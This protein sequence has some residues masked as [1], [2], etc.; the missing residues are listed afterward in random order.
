MRTA[1]TRALE[2]IVNVHPIEIQ[3]DETENDGQEFREFKS[4]HQKVIEVILGN[5]TRTESADPIPESTIITKCE[6]LIPD[7]RQ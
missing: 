2:T 6:T 1:P 5:S 4:Y 7:A 3:R